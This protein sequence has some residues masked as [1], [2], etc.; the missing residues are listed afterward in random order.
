M[1]PCLTI[2]NT[3]S[4]TQEIQL[5]SHSVKVVK[6]LNNRWC[7]LMVD[8]KLVKDGDHNC[9]ISGNDEQEKETV[10]SLNRNVFA[11]VASYLWCYQQ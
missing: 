5:S 8:S 4:L 6:A 3:N 7:G 2:H 11:F 1:P 9:F 10:R